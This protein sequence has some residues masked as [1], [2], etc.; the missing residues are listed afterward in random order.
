MP[1]PET[2]RRKLIKAIVAVG[3][4]LERE[5]AEHTIYVHSAK[6]GVL[7]VPRHAELSP[8]VARKLSIVA[9]L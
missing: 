3:W 6:P 1:L 8:G 5:G 4:K 2:N 7:S 9:G